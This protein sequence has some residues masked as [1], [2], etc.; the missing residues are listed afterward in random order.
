MSH[1]KREINQTREG[2]VGISG[3][4]YYVRMLLKKYHLK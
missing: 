3:D 1:A 2:R 4:L